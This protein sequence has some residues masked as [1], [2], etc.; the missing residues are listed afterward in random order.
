MVA[1]TKDCGPK[2]ASPYLQPLS[3][4]P[5]PLPSSR[6]G[7]QMVQSNVVQLCMH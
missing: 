3:P 5:A 7:P 6:Q 4:T 2:M 1:F